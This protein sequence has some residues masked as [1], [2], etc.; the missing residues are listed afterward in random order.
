MI[1]RTR[2]AVWM[3]SAAL[4]LASAGAG[5]GGSTPSAQGSGAEGGER[6]KRN[7]ITNILPA[8]AIVEMQTA[9]A[10]RGF[11]PGKK[12]SFDRT[13]ESALRAFQERRELV[14]TGMPDVATLRALKLDPLAIYH[15]TLKEDAQP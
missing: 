5:C 12:G 6:P 15:A 8:W 13:T 3:V 1:R 10:E 14:P 4:G 7:R 9:L 11:S 2:C